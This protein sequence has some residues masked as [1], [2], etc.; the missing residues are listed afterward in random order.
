LQITGSGNSIDGTGLATLGSTTGTYS[1]TATLGSA[2]NNASVTVAVTPIV[3][4][5]QVNDGS[6][7]RSMVDRSR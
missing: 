6:A 1:V 2:S 5:F 7:Q 4:G 3:S